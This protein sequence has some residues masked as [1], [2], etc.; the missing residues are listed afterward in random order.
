MTG[1]HPPPSPNIFTMC[2]FGLWRQ[3]LSYFM[4][5]N[6]NSFIEPHHHITMVY[7]DFTE[8][9]WD[10]QHQCY[11]Y[12]TR[13]ETDIF[14]IISMRYGELIGEHILLIFLIRQHNFF[15]FLKPV[16]IIKY[17][18]F[19]VKNIFLNLSIR[20]LCK[21]FYSFCCNEVQFM[22]QWNH[23]QFLFFTMITDSFISWYIDPTS[24]FYW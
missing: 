23:L 16:F 6:F 2:S 11:M 17:H 21:I 9:K 5:Y 4:S 19:K 13:K 22:M 15:F 12:D 8:N 20:I 7:S 10:I 3:N 24:T 1:S 18:L 14:I